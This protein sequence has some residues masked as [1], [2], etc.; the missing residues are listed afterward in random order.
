MNKKVKLVILIALFATIVFSVNCYA[1]TEAEVQAVVDSSSKESVSGNLFVWFLCAIAFMKVSQKIDSFMSSLGIS[2]GRTGGAMMGEAMI[3]A[4]TVGSA[5]KAGG[6]FAGFGKGGGSTSAGGSAPAGKTGFFGGIGRKMADGATGSVTGNANA[7]GGMMA[8]IGKKMY[9][10]SV[11]KGGAFATSV[12]GSVARGEINK[13]GTI[14]GANGKAA[15]ESYFGYNA[16][17]SVDKKEG[18]SSSMSID[19]GGSTTITSNSNVS[20]SVGFDASGQPIGSEA[21]PIGGDTSTIDIGSDGGASIPS[22]GGDTIPTF[23]DIE[24]GGGRIT[25]METSVDHPDGIQFAMYDAEKYAKPEGKFETVTAVD[26]SKWYKQ[27]AAPA[28]E[29]TPYM[30]PKGKVQYHEKIVERIPKA[31]MRKDKM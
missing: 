13:M 16:N 3:V 12:I 24:M 15:M 18:Q 14:S 31:P 28:V 4:R 22:G 1:V 21:S 7:P 9:E 26:N 23:S 6:K 5:F 25:G 2:V 17:A 20:G 19:Q 29:K 27:Y 8:S 30:D 10:N 11:G